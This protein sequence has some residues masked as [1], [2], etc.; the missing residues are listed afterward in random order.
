MTSDD[1]NRCMCSQDTN[2][3]IIQKCLHMDIDEENMV[4]FSEE[5]ISNIQFAVVPN[6]GITEIRAKSM[7]SLINL[8]ERSEDNIIP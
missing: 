7:F 6:I 1:K 8:P 4:K 3:D 2:I 5:E